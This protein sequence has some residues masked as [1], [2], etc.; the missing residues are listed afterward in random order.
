MDDKRARISVILH[1]DVVGLS[2][3]VISSRGHAMN[4]S[5]SFQMEKLVPQPQD[6]LAFG[7]L[8]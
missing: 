3:S 5:G 6:A 1:E 4:C 7:F 8:I 2:R